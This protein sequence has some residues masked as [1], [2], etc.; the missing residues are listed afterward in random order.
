MFWLGS[1]ENFCNEFH[2]ETLSKMKMTCTDTT[3]PNQK[4]VCVCVIVTSYIFENHPLTH[5]KRFLYNA[6]D[7]QPA[8]LRDTAI[9]RS[10]S[11]QLRNHYVASNKN[12][13]S[14]SMVS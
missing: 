11:C 12:E 2:N 13:T 1:V 10:H 7:I 5:S 3:K 9:L 8:T 6:C 4:C 14:D